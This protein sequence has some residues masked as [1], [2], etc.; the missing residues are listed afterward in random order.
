MLLIFQLLEIQQRLVT[1]GATYGEDSFRWV[2]FEYDY[3]YN[4]TP[5][6]NQLL[7]NLPCVL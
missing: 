1:F 4:K 7:Y 5:F 2:N 3:K 6:T